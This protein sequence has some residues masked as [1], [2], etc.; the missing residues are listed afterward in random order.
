M[1]EAAAFVFAGGVL[2]AAA[3]WP[4]KALDAARR[5]RVLFGLLILIVLIY[6]GF[7]VA[8]GDPRAIALEALAGLVFIPVALIAWPI[9]RYALPGLILAH[10]GIDAAHLLTGSPIIPMWYAQACVGFDAALGLGALTLFSRSQSGP[11]AGEAT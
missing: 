3:L 1:L 10:G 9:R 11:A 2:G 4:L 8:Y 5:W 6:A 7:A